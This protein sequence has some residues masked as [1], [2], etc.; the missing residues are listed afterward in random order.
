MVRQLKGTVES[1]MKQQ[2]T[3]FHGKSMVGPWPL[4]YFRYGLSISGILQVIAHNMKTFLG[5]FHK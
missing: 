3:E 4:W 2:H 1:I 5:G